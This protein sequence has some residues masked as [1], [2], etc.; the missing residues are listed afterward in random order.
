VH[1]LLVQVNGDR[2]R[3]A[4]GLSGAPEI[5]NGDDRQAKDLDQDDVLHVP[6]FRL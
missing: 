2:R 3:L 1:P 6:G 4:P 5:I